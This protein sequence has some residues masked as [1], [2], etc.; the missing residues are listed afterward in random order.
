MIKAFNF[1]K[2][3]SKPIQLPV[4]VRFYEE[5]G[6]KYL[7]RMPV[8]A[9]NGIVYLNSIN[10]ESS[11]CVRTFV[12]DKS[13]NI[14]GH[15]EYYISEN[16]LDGDYMEVDYKH[17]GNGLGELLR[18]ASLMMCK[19]NNLD[20]IKLESLS[21]ALPFHI[22]YRFKPYFPDYKQETMSN[23]LQNIILRTNEAGD[24]NKLAKK[25]LADFYSSRDES[26]YQDSLSGLVTRYV[27]QNR[28]RWDDQN[29]VYNVPL[30]L[31]KNMLKAN[32][33]YYNKLFKKHEIDYKI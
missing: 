31:D 13:F 15:H 2:P 6:I 5:D 7:N 29:F 19:E 11:E 1:I 9:N 33:D 20:G 24:L 23:L 17:Q 12:T 10:D 8:R 4:K 22:K 28:N 3:K 26:Q 18:L 14:L 25:L 30:M 27:V 32:A 16:V 21:T